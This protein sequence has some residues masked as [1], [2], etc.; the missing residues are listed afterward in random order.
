M[1]LLKGS[2]KPTAAKKKKAT[3]STCRK[4]IPEFI[5]IQCYCPYFIYKASIVSTMKAI[6]FCYTSEGDENVL[7]GIWSN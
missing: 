7:K 6:L 2:D 5:N 4:N 3:R 1:F